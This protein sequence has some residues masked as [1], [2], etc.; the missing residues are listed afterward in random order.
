VLLKWMYYLCY[1]SWH[2]LTGTHIERHN[3]SRPNYLWK[4]S[5]AHTRQ[6]LDSGIWPHLLPYPFTFLPSISSHNWPRRCVFSGLFSSSFMIGIDFKALPFHP[7]LSAI[8]IIA[9]PWWMREMT[10]ANDFEKHIPKARIFIIAT[11]FLYSDRS[12]LLI[13]TWWM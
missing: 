6:Y 3:R 13:S 9:A 5:P 4:T 11:S 12:A 1:L 2:C 10:V 8:R 7:D